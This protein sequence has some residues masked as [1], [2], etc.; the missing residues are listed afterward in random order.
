[1]AEA[2]IAHINQSTR[3]L[4]LGIWGHLSRRRRL[5]LGLLRVVMLA[6]G[7]A[8]LVSLG[9]VL[10]FLA[11]LSDPERLWQQPL[12]QALAGRVGFTQASELLLP[13]TLA[14]AVAAVLAAVVVEQLRLGVPRATLELDFPQLSRQ[15][16][17][18]AEIQARLPKP[19]GRPR[20]K[21]QLQ[22]G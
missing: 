20:T 12:V 15:A 16:L 21:L 2:E 18:Y 5:Q 1:M 10:P 19:P 8:E 14:F 4:L 3:T 7:G 6:S 11:V 17:D 13:A 22:R 9:A